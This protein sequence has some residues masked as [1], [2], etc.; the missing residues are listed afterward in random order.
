[1]IGAR[2]LEVDRRATELGGPCLNGP[3]QRTS[4]AAAALVA[5]HAEIAQ[6]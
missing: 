6:P 5:G 2:K 3:Y 1:M 4:Y